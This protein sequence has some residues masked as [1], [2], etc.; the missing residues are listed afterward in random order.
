MTETHEVLKGACWAAALAPSAAGVSVPDQDASA[1][2]EINSIELKHRTQTFETS[3]CLKCPWQQWVCRCPETAN[4]KSLVSYTHNTH[5]TH[6]THTDEPAAEAAAADRGHAEQG[7]QGRRENGAGAAAHRQQNAA[8]G[9]AG[10]RLALPVS[11][12]WAPAEAMFAPVFVHSAN[13]RLHICSRITAQRA[14]TAHHTMTHMHS[15]SVPE[16]S[17][18]WTVLQTAGPGLQPPTAESPSPSLTHAHTTP[19]N[20]AHTQGARAW[21]RLDRA[22][23]PGGS[24]WVHLKCLNRLN[25]CVN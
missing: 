23:A 14:S 8:G 21:R 10:A 24:R 19:H 4:G 13:T 7:H 3:K 2:G 17:G 20:N 11:K 9:A 5:N 25:L 16:P 1:A 6:A 12:P 22:A 15:C 18:G